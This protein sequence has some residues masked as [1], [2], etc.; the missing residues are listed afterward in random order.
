M[1]GSSAHKLPFMRNYAEAH[2][3]F[4][5][6]RKPPRSAKW[7]EHQRPLKNT[8]AYHYRIEKNEDS[9]DI[10]LYHTV[11]ARYY[12]PDAQ[13]NERRLYRGH[14]SQTSRQFMWHVLCIGQY[15]WNTTTDGRDVATP[16][17]DSCTFADNGKMFSADFMFTPDNKLIVEQSHHTPHYKYVSSQEDKDKRAHIRKQLSNYAMLA[18]LRLP[19]YEGDVELDHRKGTPFSG[20]NGASMRERDAIKDML[21][22]EPTGDSLQF[23]F[24][25]ICQEVFDVLASKRAY[26]QDGFKMGWSGTD[27]YSTLEKRIT[28]HEFEKAVLKRCLDIVGANVQS[29]RREIPQFINKEDYPRSNIHV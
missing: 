20:F 5:N 10:V 14:N 8:S 26:N 19:Q 3:H 23:F 6:T 28:Q 22:E 13:G 4:T 25:N 16:V 2:A 27:D 12:K 1:Y 29:E 24:D 7:S 21:T 11:M 15:R 9:Y 18:A 17:Y